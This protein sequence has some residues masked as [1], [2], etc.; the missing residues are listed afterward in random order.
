M[1]TEIGHPAV[2]PDLIDSIVATYAPRRIIL[3]GS[4][5]RGDARRDS[6]LDLI[7]EVDDDVAPDL[8]RWGTATRARRGYDGSV[9]IIPCRAR[10]MI[11]FADVPGT[12]AHEAWLEGV[13][14]Y[15]RS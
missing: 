7:V 15:E 9:D 6:D 2:P 5:A 3:F 11:D 12:L 8:L 4:T 13:V 14:V 10:R 1:R